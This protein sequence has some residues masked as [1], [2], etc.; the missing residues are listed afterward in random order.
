MRACVQLCSQLCDPCVCAF[1]MLCVFRGVDKLDLADLA[2]GGVSSDLADSAIPRPQSPLVGE[3][4]KKNKF[5]VHLDLAVIDFSKSHLST[6]CLIS[7]CW[8]C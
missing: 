4:R 8:L 6:R 3:K 5:S 7:E 1:G 2:L